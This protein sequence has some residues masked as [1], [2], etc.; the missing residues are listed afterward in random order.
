MPAAQKII[1]R[2]SNGQFVVKSR[3]KQF[4]TQDGLWWVGSY[5]ELTEDDRK[6]WQQKQLRAYHARMDVQ[7]DARYERREH[8]IATM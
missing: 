7:E 2:H 8:D 4:Q 3:G 6:E 1:G 5:A